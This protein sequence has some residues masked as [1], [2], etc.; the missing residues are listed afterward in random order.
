MTYIDKTREHRGRT[1]YHAGRAA[2]QAVIGQ[3][4]DRGYELV[5]ERWRGAGGE[6]DLVFQQDALF[7]F[8]E[9]KKSRTHADA[10]LRIGAGQAGRI[11]AAATVFVA[12][13]PSGQMSDMRFDAALVDS[14]GKIEIIENALS[15]G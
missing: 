11:L 15:M 3:Y 7:V 2:E 4:K 14:M 8:V 1:A 5:A 6:I 10:A 13:E 12:D 9:V